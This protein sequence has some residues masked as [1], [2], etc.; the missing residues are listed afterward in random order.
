MTTKAKKETAQTLPATLSPDQL[1]AEIAAMMEED[2]IHREAF[3]SDMLIIPRLELLQDLSPEVR[4]RHAEYI[5]GAK[6][7]MI[8]NKTRRTLDTEILFVPARFFLRY[9]AWRP[10]EG[11]GGGGLVDPNLTREDA[12]TNF[13]PDG[14]ARWVGLMPVPGK[15]HPVNVEVIETPEWVGFAKSENFDWMP[16]AISFPIT[17]AKVAREIN[18][19]IDMTRLPRAGGGKY[20]P[21]S[22]SH[23]FKLDTALETGGENEYFNWRQFWVGYNTDV[24]I[25]NEAR[26]LRL[27]FDEGRAAVEDPTANAA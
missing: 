13:R 18:T 23:V 14:I 3:N 22:F 12:E 26:A 17:K 7:G 8:Y 21:A 9:I 20:V 25:I 2:S 11:S 5:P 15:E 6:P 4:E 19:V 1:P 16:V 27:S 10:R 24:E